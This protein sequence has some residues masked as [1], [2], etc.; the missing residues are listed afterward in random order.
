MFKKFT[1]AMILV[2]LFAIPAFSADEAN[3]PINALSQRPEKSIYAM[4]QVK[5]LSGFLSWLLSR[6]NLNIAAKFAED[7]MLD[8]DTI[9]IICNIVENLNLTDTALIGGNDTGTIDAFFAQAAFKI[10]DGNEELL[11]NFKSGKADA[12]DVAKLLIGNSALTPMLASM[13]DVKFDNGIYTISSMAF[14]SVMPDDVFI[15]ASSVEEIFKAVAAYKGDARAIDNIARKFDTPDFIYTH[16]DC[17]LLGSFDK[18]VEKEIAKYFKQPLNIETAFNVQ[19]DKFILSMYGNFREALADKYT[20]KVDKYV[21]VK[22]GHINFDAVGGAGS[23]LFAIGMTIDMDEIKDLSVFKDLLNN[24]KFIRRFG[25]TNDDLIKFLN[26]AFSLVIND[27][28]PFMGLKL[29]AV[30]FSQTSEA[31]PAVFEKLANAKQFSEIKTDYAY[32]EKLLQADN[33]LSPVSCLVGKSGNTL[34]VSIAE[35]TSF[36]ARPVL[37][38]TLQN[39]A[40]SEGFSALWA[41]FGG[42]QKWLQDTGAL[43]MFGMIAMASGAGEEYKAFADIMNAKFSVPYISFSVPAIEMMN[44]EFGLADVPAGEGVL[45]KV[46]DAYVKF[47]KK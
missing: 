8:A 33:S 11:Q 35:A 45:S 37:N 38:P 25:I 36:A 5:N 20:A 21:P 16:S 34:G 40:D 47:G 41:D 24:I 23:P 19:P 44:F 13:L 12:N 4:T 9:E 30:F 46:A 7:G 43:G 29:P 39:I 27:S 28:V 31:A 1:A 2:A 10:K 6:E 14:L 15:L 18:D 17:G 42:F 26:G 32:W 3:N 22:G